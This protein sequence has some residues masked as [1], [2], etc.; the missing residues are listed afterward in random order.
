MSVEKMIK[1]K[2]AN[3]SNTSRNVILYTNADNTT[4]PSGSIENIMTRHSPSKTS[5]YFK[6]SKRSLDGFGLTTKMNADLPLDLI[7]R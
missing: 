3:P 2:L 6:V 7:E 5:N 4:T 1:S